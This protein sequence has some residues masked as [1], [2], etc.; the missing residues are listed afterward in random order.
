MH[1]CRSQV[2]QGRLRRH[3]L[4]HL[5]NVDASSRLLNVDASPTVRP[6]ANPPRHPM[7]P[8][9]RTRANP[10][11]HPKTFQNILV[12]F[13]SNTCILL[14]K[15]NSGRPSIY[16]VLRGTRCSKKSCRLW[17]PVPVAKVIS[18]LTMASNALKTTS[19]V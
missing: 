14:Q 11:I 15:N 12:S 13:R 16:R 7:S 10:P 2:Q 9:V 1:V 19:A 5:L 4:L 17:I 6:R 18:Y 3:L 8:T